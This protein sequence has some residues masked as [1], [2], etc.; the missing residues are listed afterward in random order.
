MFQQIIEFCRTR[1]TSRVRG[2]NWRRGSYR[3]ALEE[4]VTRLR[5]QNRALVNSILGVA[6]I[7]PMRVAPHSAV[8]GATLTSSGRPKGR[9]YVGKSE[10]ANRNT[11]PVSEFVAAD[12][13]T[14]ASRQPETNRPAG[15]ELQMPCALC[16]AVLTEENYV[17]EEVITVPAG[18][19]TVRVANGQEVIT[20]VGALELKTPP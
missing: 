14:K 18:V 20:I 7:P 15:R 16:G 6:G 17:P 4:E 5:A 10:A 2:A 12:G 9:A 1:F 19:R 13:E 8:V 11:R 3:R